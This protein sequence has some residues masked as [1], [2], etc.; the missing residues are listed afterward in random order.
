MI[1][2]LQIENFHLNFSYGD[3]SVP[4]FLL[5]ITRGDSWFLWCS[6]TCTT[7]PCVSWARTINFEYLSNSSLS[8]GFTWNPPACAWWI[9]CHGEQCRHKNST[10]HSPTALCSDVVLGD[11]W[12]SCRLSPGTQGHVQGRTQP[13]GTQLL[14]AAPCPSRGAA[15]SW[16][17]SSACPPNTSRQQQHQTCTGDGDRELSH[18]QLSL[19]FVAK[20]IHF[21]FHSCQ[22]GKAAL[23]FSVF[24]EEGKT[25]VRVCNQVLLIRTDGAGLLLQNIYSS[26][27]LSNSASCFEINKL[28]LQNC[29][30][31][32]KVCPLPAQAVVTDLTKGFFLGELMD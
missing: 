21:I 10:L 23:F 6:S 7:F 30:V 3:V 17:P 16:A 1:S 27:T 25:G 18:W 24:S 31:K 8:F 13:W 15:Q 11:S 2:P 19:I 4:V 28:L 22:L 29:T 32:A 14:W 20:T 5:G 26:Y 12:G 9:F